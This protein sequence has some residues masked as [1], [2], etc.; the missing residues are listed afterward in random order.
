MLLRLRICPRKERTGFNLG[1]E[2]A[3]GIAIVST[4][5]QRSSWRMDCWTSGI[6]RVAGKLDSLVG[7]RRYTVIGR[8]GREKVAGKPVT[9]PADA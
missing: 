7:H 8:A 3:S 6:I 2:R 9:L 4:I 5:N 1:I